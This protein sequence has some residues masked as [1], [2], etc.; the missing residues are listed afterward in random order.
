MELMRRYALG[1]G[2]FAA[3]LVAAPAVAA[4]GNTLDA[5]SV[6][7]GSGTTATNFTFSVHYSSRRGLAP[8]SVHASAGGR[9]VTLSL[10]SGTAADGIYR[11][12][13]R[14]P[15]GSW[16][17]LFTAT[18]SQGKGGILAGPTIKV[19]PVATPT[20]APTPRPAAVT[21]PAPQVLPPVAP[22]APAAPTA[23]VI[24]PAAPAP[25]A[26]APVATPKQKA[27]AA[28][29]TKT[30]PAPAH[31]HPP[32]SVALPAPTEDTQQLSNMMLGGVGVIGL[33][34]AFW[35]LIAGRRRDAPVPEAIPEVAV[36]PPKAPPKP[37]APWEADTQLDDEPIGTVD[38]LPLGAGEAI[39]TPPPKQP[40]APRT[41]PHAA[42][43]QAARNSRE[44]YGR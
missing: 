23:V 5:A 12:V 19:A 41:N 13:G 44:T 10:V 16:N 28:V 27:P 8:R 31:S 1:A 25:K 24:P 36:A 37:P 26:A 33:V 43:I 4:A 2:L 34:A 35:F 17:V 7:P 22:A 6:S 18:V 15:V 40:R 38:Y 3:A 32:S 20:L 42:R 11:G 21:T 29:I 30:S 9:T 39:G 14:L